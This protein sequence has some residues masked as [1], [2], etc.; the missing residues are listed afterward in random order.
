MKINKLMDRFKKT[1]GEA[2]YEL[3]GISKGTYGVFD[4]VG[5]MEDVKKIYPDAVVKLFEDSTDKR[6]PLV[7]Y[8]WE[9]R[10]S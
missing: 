3:T 4:T 7:V 5:F 10:E 1:N 6:Y 9:K 2:P 8:I